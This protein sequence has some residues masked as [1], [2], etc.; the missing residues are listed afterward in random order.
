MTERGQ[1]TELAAC[2]GAD[3][4]LFFDKYAVGT[5][6][7]RRA[8]DELCYSCPVIRQC[9]QYRDRFKAEGVHAGVYWRPG[10]SAAPA[11]PHSTLNDHKT[12]QDWQLLHELIGI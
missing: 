11:E 3:G 2:S 8:V 9:K 6:D 12:D 7:Q 5:P 1:W 10:T 4:D